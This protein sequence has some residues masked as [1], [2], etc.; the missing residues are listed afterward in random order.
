MSDDFTDDTPTKQITVPDEMLDAVYPEIRCKPPTDDISTAD[1][2]STFHDTSLRA[3]VK[4]P[5]VED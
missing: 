3:T 4:L 2:E 1:A 5:A